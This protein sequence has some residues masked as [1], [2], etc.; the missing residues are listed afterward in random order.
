MV[1][2]LTFEGSIA[3]SIYADE[4]PG[5]IY[6][7][8]NDI[9]SGM[10]RVMRTTLA[11]SDA[12]FLNIAYEDEILIAVDQI[13]LYVLVKDQNRTDLYYKTSSVKVGEFQLNTKVKEMIV[14]LGKCKVY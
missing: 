3:Q 4:V 10:F 9:Q 12:L 13:Y 5:V 11:T 2:Q 14:A 7:V 1:R 6:W 8:A